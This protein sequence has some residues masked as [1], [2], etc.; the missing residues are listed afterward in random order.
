MDK[1]LG[2]A[3]L[4]KKCQITIPKTVRVLL[5]LEAGDTIEFVLEEKKI[6]VRKTVE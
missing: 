2:R 6:V 1:V 4:S 3:K 5:E